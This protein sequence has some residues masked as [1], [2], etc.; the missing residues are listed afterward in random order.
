MTKIY[1]ENDGEKIERNTKHIR[2]QE[3]NSMYTHTFMSGTRIIYTHIHWYIGNTDNIYIH[4][5]NK[6]NIYAHTFVS[7]IRII[8]RQVH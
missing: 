6:G 1:D 2:E 5:G 3:E 4:I 8:R 7:G